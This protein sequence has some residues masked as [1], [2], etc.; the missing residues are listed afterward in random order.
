[1]LNNSAI[2]QR[3]SPVKSIY[4][5]LSFLCNFTSRYQIRERPKRSIEASRP[6]GI[7]T[8]IQINDT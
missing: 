8:L 3:L 6:R 2:L 4:Q 5:K 1:M 7:A